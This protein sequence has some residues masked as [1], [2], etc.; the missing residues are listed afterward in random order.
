MRKERLHLIVDNLFD[1]T[2]LEDKLLK[3]LS[4][5]NIEPRMGGNE[6][7]RP[8]RIEERKPVKI[9]VD[10]EVAVGIQFMRDSGRWI[11]RCDIPFTFVT[12][13]ARKGLINRAG[14]FLPCTP[15]CLSV[16]D[17][18]SRGIFGSE[19]YSPV[20]HTVGCRLRYRNRPFRL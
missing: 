14:K 7:K 10:I 4:I 8:F 9:E 1:V 13:E 15:S 18:L 17:R 20:G 12:K 19:I 5:A 2:V 16:C 6:T 11:I 3:I